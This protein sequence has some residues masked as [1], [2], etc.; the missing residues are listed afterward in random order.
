MIS[1]LW[2]SPA[3]GANCGHRN[4][5][6]VSLAFQ[7]AGLPL[8]LETRVLEDFRAG[9]SSREIDVCREA[10]GPGHSAVAAVRV[11][12][13][14][15]TRVG[16]SVEVRDRVTAK[17]L[18]RDLDLSRVPEDGRAFAVALAADELLRASWVE[19]AL[20]RARQPTSIA[21]PEVTRVVESELASARP[22][23]LRLAIRA[24]AERFSG[25]QTQVGG[26]L[27]LAVSLAPRFEIDLAAGLREAL[28]VTAPHGRVLA[29]AVGAGAS[30][31]YLL[32]RPSNFQ[33]SSFVGGR[34]SWVRFRGEAAS[35][36]RADELSGLV[37]VARS[38]L[39]ARVHLTGPFRAECGVNAGAVLRALGAND[40]AETVTAMSGLE[41]AVH[42]GLAA[43][44]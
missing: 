38:G 37:V 25:G 28:P 22:R 40:T 9:L 11:V 8:E 13:A 34:A 2:N 36:G 7:R 18:A 24:S 19:L 5:P 32:L 44:F 30:I 6:W 31:G 14:S 16:V 27:A 17:R 21:P 1:L 4:R 15:A 42:A 43:E 26:D 35:D 29:S 10:A 20:E 41:L 3:V 33:L 23:R 12:P 39:G